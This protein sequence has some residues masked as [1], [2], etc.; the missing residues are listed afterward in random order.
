MQAETQD[1]VRVAEELRFA[2]EQFGHLSG[3]IGLEE[4]LDVVFA[5]F[6]IGK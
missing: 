6:C 1:V 2:A 5:D 4:I 3:R